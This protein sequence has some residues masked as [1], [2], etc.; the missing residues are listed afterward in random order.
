MGSLGQLSSLGKRLKRVPM[1]LEKY[2]EIIQEQLAEEIVEKVTDEPRE[3]EL[4]ILCTQISQTGVST[5]H[6]N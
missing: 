5:E 6:Q 1:L 3:N 2:D 4:Y